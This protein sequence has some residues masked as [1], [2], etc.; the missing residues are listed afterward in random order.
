[1]E[2]CRRQWRELPEL[3]GHKFRFVASESPAGEF[4]NEFLFGKQMEAFLDN[5]A[6]TIRLSRRLTGRS[7]D[8]PDALRGFITQHYREIP[9]FNNWSAAWL[10]TASAWRLPDQQFATGK[11]PFI[12]PGVPALFVLAACGVLVAMVLPGRLRVFHIAWGLTLFGLFFIIMLT[13]NVRP[14]FRLFFEPFWLGYVAMLVECLWL[15]ATRFL[16]RRP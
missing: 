10:R 6:R 14:R 1:M 9:W 13:A 11:R 3:V 15:A 16:P 8:S 4:T 7:L 2:I 12:Y 5:P